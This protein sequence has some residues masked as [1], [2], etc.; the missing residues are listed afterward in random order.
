MRAA[1]LSLA[2]FMLLLA[3]P[4]PGH[5]APVAAPG[6]ASSSGVEDAA[7]RRCAR[8]YHY[9]KPHRLRNGQVVPGRCVLN[10]RRR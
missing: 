10:R 7:R 4:A 5:A 1:F 8:G 9:V 2:A 3:L 6:I